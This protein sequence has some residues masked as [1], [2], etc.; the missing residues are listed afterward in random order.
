[1]NLA[2]AQIQNQPVNLYGFIA[3]Y[4]EYEINL[5][6]GNDAI[7]SPTFPNLSLDAEQVLSGII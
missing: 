6:R 4:G 5:F 1:M 7:A 3:H 2:I